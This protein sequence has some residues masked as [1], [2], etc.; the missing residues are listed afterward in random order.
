MPD[1]KSTQHR[2]D[3]IRKSD[4]NAFRIVHG[5]GDGMRGFYLDSFGDYLLASKDGKPTDHETQVVRF[6]MSK[7]QAKGAFLKRLDR[8]SGTVPASMVS[9]VAWMGNL[10]AAKTVIYES[11]VKYQIRFDEGYSVGIFLDQRDNR[12]RWLN[13]DVCPGF[14]MNFHDL[15][16]G[17]M[18][19]TFSYTCAFSVCAGKN[20]MRSVSLDLSRKYLDWGKENFKLNR[21]DPHAHD[22]IYGDTFDW[23]RRFKRRGRKFS[24]IVID[25][26]TFSRVSK[27]GKTFRAE[28]DY[29]ELFRLAL[30]VLEPNG[31]V[32][33]C[34]NT[35]GLSHVQFERMIN[36]S[37]FQS[38]AQ[39]ARFH[40]AAQPVDFP[41]T[42]ACPQYLK[43]VW[44]QIK[45]IKE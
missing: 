4:T 21:L 26:P 19:N 20:R 39:C 23:L 42:P 13:S 10:H 25:P 14:R 7:L 29:P 3:L 1:N 32:L 30:E 27:T 44:I 38:G 15:P 6:W 33:A 17:E 16:S 2:L 43:S 5:N 34:N 45:S 37:L 8:Q 24:A 22:F 36:Q 28:K 31:V 12:L 18:L 40:T 35:I 41:V 9:P 11:G